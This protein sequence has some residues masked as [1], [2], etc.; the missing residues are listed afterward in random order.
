VILA[1]DDIDLWL[2]P[3]AD[4]EDVWRLLVPFDDTKMTVKLAD[5]SDFKRKSK[6]EAAVTEV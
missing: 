4:M 3:K 6:F 2:D 5:P 1:P